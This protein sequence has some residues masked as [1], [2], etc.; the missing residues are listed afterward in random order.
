M[1]QKQQQFAKLI[2]PGQGA[3]G[4]RTRESSLKTR[5]TR[6][7]HEGKRE[8]KERFSWAETRRGPS[9]GPQNHEKWRFFTPKIWVITPKNEGCGFPWFCLIDW[10]GFFHAKMWGERLFF[11]GISTRMVYAHF[12]NIMM[13]NWMWRIVDGIFKGLDPEMLGKLQERAKAPSNI[14]TNITRKSK[15]LALV[16]Q[17]HTI[18]LKLIDHL[19]SQWLVD[20]WRGIYRTNTITGKNRQ[21]PFC[22]ERCFFCFCFVS[23]LTW[24]QH[25]RWAQTPDITWVKSLL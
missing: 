16:S 6:R 1:D 17:F 7:R 21:A 11:G 19:P 9:L 5:G 23:L 10:R 18:P 2:T 14:W 3:S 4:K 20:G 13:W 22:H 8:A 15:S 25:A 24:Q 12:Y